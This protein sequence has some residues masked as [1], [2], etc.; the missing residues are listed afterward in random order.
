MQYFTS[1]NNTPYYHWQAELLI[2]SFRM[3]G[4]ED[5]LWIGIANPKA[6]ALQEYTINL[7]SH[8]NKFFFEG[9]DGHPALGR[10]YAAVLALKHGAIKPP[11]ALIDSDMVLLKPIEDVEKDIVFHTAEEDERLKSVLEPRI[12][13][14]LKEYNVGREEVGWM[15]V[16]HTVVFNNVDETLFF[17]AMLWGERLVQEEGDDMDVERAAWIMAFHDFLLKH[18]YGN[19]FYELSMLHNDVDAPLVH[20]QRGLPPDF[21]KR[22][23]TFDGGAIG[24]LAA[25]GSPYSA[26][27]KNNPTTTTEKMQEVVKSYLGREDVQ[28]AQGLVQ[29]EGTA[30]VEGSVS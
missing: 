5:Q 1:I 17:R 14:L 19:K 9:Y 13:K 12:K 30:T 16:G 4:M 8:P 15:P 21:V 6:N 28:L 27:L 2:E 10:I 25:G 23:F 7:R 11:F 24:F 3:L 18:N 29:S 22:N 26:I 20:Y